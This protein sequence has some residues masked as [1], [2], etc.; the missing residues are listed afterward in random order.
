MGWL[1]VLF[2]N[3][4]PWWLSWSL[5]VCHSEKLSNKQQTLF[6]NHHVTHTIPSFRMQFPGTGTAD[7]FVRSLPGM[8]LCLFIDRFCSRANSFVRRVGTVGMVIYI[9]FLVCAR[10]CVERVIYVTLHNQI[11]FMLSIT[12][13]L[14]IEGHSSFDHRVHNH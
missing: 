4:I 3:Q 2:S 8:V 12:F 11:T 10:V 13:T 14:N 9:T 1:L 5:T 6:L 7:W